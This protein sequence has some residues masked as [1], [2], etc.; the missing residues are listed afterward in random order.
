MLLQEP[1]VSLDRGCREGAL[2]DSNLEDLQPGSGD[3]FKRLGVGRAQ[4]AALGT[5]IEA[6]GQEAAGIRVEA[7]CL[8]E[9]D[10]GIDTQRNRV[11]QAGETVTEAPA[12]G[13]LGGGT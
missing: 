6:A 1:P 12:L 5:G 3:G 4:P 7:S 10:F 9:A 8:C 13:A 11:L 2:M